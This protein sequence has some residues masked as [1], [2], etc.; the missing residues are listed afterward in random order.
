MLAALQSLVTALE[1]NPASPAC[2]L[3]VLPLQE[4]QQ[5]LAWNSNLTGESSDRLI[6]QLFEEQVKRQPQAI[7]VVDGTR[8][9][10]YAELN[11]QADQLARNLRNLGVLS[12]KIVLLFVLIAVWRCWWQYS[13]SS[14]LG[15]PIFPLIQLIRRDGSNTC[16]TTGRPRFR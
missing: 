5:L 14:R 9:L 3:E 15:V 4:H 16:S 12:L 6:H 13:P 8:T 1:Q 7:A 10:T 2:T 11:R